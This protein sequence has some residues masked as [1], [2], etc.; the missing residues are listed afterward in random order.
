[1]V[2]VWCERAAGRCGLRARMADE[3]GDVVLAFLGRHQIAGID[4]GR[5]LT[6]VGTVGIRD[7]QPVILNPYYWLHASPPELA[8][9]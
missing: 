3:S 5:R 1:M 8:D 6:V 9:A 4:R 7:G 2:D